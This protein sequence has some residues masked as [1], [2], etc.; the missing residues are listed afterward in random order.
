M[1]TNC[2]YAGCRISLGIGPGELE[3][4]SDEFVEFVDKA[5]IEPIEP[6][7]P[8]IDVYINISRF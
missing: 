2:M 3:I 5:E 8:A 7:E 1:I 4:E 6:I